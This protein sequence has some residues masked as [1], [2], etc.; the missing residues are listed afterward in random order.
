MPKPEISQY[1]YLHGKPL[2]GHKKL[3]KYPKNGIFMAKTYVRNFAISKIFQ[4][5]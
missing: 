3:Q 4:F 1:D 2:L 5:S